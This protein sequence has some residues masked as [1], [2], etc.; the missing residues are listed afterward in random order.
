MIMGKLSPVLASRPPALQT[1]A[2]TQLRNMW[3]MG[4][5]KDQ[6]LAHSWHSQ[7]LLLSLLNL[8]TF[9][10]VTSSSLSPAHLLNES[11]CGPLAHMPTQTLVYPHV[12][13]HSHA[14]CKLSPTKAALK[15]RVRMHAYL[16]RPPLQTLREP[17]VYQA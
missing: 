7:D 6:C 2:T 1:W 5:L 12:D 17:T 13:F 9:L 16:P 11:T 15:E 3:G 14:H 8:S 10:F 4:V